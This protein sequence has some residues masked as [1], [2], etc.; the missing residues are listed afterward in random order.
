MAEERDNIINAIG[1]ER[2]KQKRK[3]FAD[4]I[5]IDPPPYFTGLF[6]IFIDLHYFCPNGITYQDIASYGAATQT[7][8]SVYEVGLIRKMESWAASEINKAYRENL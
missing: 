6:G 4:Y 7:A 1:R 8:L 5:D 2:W 3:D